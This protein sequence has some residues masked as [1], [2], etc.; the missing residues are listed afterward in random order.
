MHN[1]IHPLHPY[2]SYEGIFAEVYHNS[3]SDSLYSFYWLVSFCLVQNLTLLEPLNFTGLIL[4][5][6]VATILANLWGEE[7]L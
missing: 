1:M 4:Q 3:V 2:Q 7:D 5:T 6:F